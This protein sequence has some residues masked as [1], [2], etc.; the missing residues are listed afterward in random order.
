MTKQFDVPILLLIFNRPEMTRKVLA[1]IRLIKPKKLY[2]AADGPR[3]KGDISKC[4]AARKIV[5]EVN[6]PCRVKTLFQD[7]NLGCGLGPVTGINWF[8][9]HVEAGIILEDD[10]LP[11]PSFLY[12]CQELLNH[13]WNNSSIMHIS[14]NNFQYG[15]KFGH[16]SYYFSQ[17]THN[18]GWATWRRAWR[19]NNYRLLSREKRKQVW[20]KQWLMSVEKA[21]GLAILPNVNLVSNIGFGAEATHTKKIERYA[22]LP[23]QTM[24]FPLVHP[25]SISRNVMA[26]FLTY[27]NH[28]GGSTLGFIFQELSK[29]I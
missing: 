1:S 23:L 13:Y 15:K 5:K 6:W 10:C 9:K 25:K 29:L 26:D 19:H 4:L 11:A 27:H 3:D 17:Y 8:F 7:N 18:W 21:K 28:F 2:I 20:D 22:K 24:K 16:G 14:G 12:F